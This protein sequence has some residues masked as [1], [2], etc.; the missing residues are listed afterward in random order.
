MAVLA[1][2]RTCRAAA[3]HEDDL[4]AVQLISPVGSTPGEATDSHPVP[5]LDGPTVEVSGNGLTWFE[6]GKQTDA[7]GIT[8]LGAIA[9]DGSYR[10]YPLP[11]PSTGVFVLALP[12]GLIDVVG[13]NGKVWQAHGA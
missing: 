5:L 11:D 3:A 12:N 7:G 1:N 4:Q 10:L 13:M 6:T 2:E 8:Q 9:L